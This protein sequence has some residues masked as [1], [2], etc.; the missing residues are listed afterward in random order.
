MTKS[1]IKLLL[2]EDSKLALTILQRLLSNSPDISVVGTATN[3]KKAL[4]LIP[5]L[6]PDVICTDLKMEGMN[7]LELTQAIMQKFPRPIL[8]ISNAVNKNDTNNVFNLLQAGAVDV[9][10]KPQGG[11]VA[12]YEAIKQQ[13]ITKIKI[14]AGVS[15]FTKPHRKRKS[16]PTSQ[17]QNQSNT[18]NQ[19]KGIQ[20][21]TIGS[22]TGGPNA[23]S[24]ILTQLKPHAI[25]L[26]I[27]CVQHISPGF[28]SGLVN[29]LGVESGLKVKI[30]ADKELPVA[31]TVYFAP[32]NYHLGIDNRGRFTYL[33]QAAVDGH[34]PS[35]TVTFT[36]IAEYYGH[37]AL[38]ILL[39][40][41]GK[42]GAAGMKAIHERGGITIAQDEKTCIVFG[43][44]KEAIALN[45]VRHILPLERIIP[46]LTKNLA[47]FI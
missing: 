35:V 13:L 4:E 6:Q 27:V 38:A 41:M 9:F 2:V 34:K 28:L 19:E 32:E 31:G 17:Q 36:S 22:S 8:V 25:T 37:Q 11:E 24:K 46:F 23:L 12:D 33:K 14:V 7:G 39:T 45:A 21:I 47:L 5:Q 44:P 42:D 3:G 26:P 10:P 30:A 18:N 43:M 20:I 29:W 40:G 1:A 16:Q 15:V